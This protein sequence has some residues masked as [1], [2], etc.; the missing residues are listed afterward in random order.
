MYTMCVQMSAVVPKLMADLL[1]LELKAVVK[2]PN[3]GSGKLPTGAAGILTTKPSLQ[4]ATETQPQIK[5]R[6]MGRWFSASEHWP[7]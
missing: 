3:V 7:L 6:E 4:L 1:G 5:G 2:S